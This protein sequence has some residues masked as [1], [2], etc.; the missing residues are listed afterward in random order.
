M[1]ANEG[2]GEG[3]GQYRF[4]DSPAINIQTQEE[5]TQSPEEHVQEES[6]YIEKYNLNRWEAL[7]QK[8]NMQRQKRTEEIKKRQQEYEQELLE[9][10]SFQPKIIKNEIYGQ[11]LEEEPDL[12]TYDRCTE[13][14]RAVDNKVSK[15]KEKNDRKEKGK[16][17]FMPQL[18]ADYKNSI[19]GYKKLE[20]NINKKAI[21]KYLE[22]MIITRLR[23]E[24][25]QMKE[26]KKCGS[27]NLWNVSS[28]VPSVPKLSKNVGSKST[29]NICRPQTEELNYL[30]SS[31]PSKE[32]FS[33]FNKEKDQFIQFQPKMS[34]GEA[35]NLIHSSILSL[36]D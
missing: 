26:H 10:C 19:K 11:N 18:Q 24:E 3:E 14:R 36:G 33:R 32:H 12:T 7:Y 4:E 2:E 9:E 15:I 1:S 34:Y 25:K 23:E 27:G 31:T 16:C 6:Y 5:D 8:D 35:V 30:M 21:D 22:R 13:W 28:T 29:H 20:K 17:T